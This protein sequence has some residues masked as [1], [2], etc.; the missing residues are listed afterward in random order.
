MIYDNIKRACKKNGVAIRKLESD[1]DLSQG[2]VCKWNSVSPSVA[3]IKKVADYL[4]VTVDELIS[5]KVS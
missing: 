2:S 3:S 4:G 1:L 5:E